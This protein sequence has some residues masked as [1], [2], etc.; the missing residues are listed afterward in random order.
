MHVAIVIVIDFKHITRFGCLSTGTRFLV[1][2][3][4][5]ITEAKLDHK[6]LVLSLC[7]WAPGKRQFF[8]HH[9]PVGWS[10]RSLLASLVAL[11]DLISILKVL[12][13][14][15]NDPILINNSV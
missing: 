9:R 8:I 5:T 7:C 14:F 15:V 4:E 13:P 1:T 12:F 10:V 3:L 2:G 6:V 11:V